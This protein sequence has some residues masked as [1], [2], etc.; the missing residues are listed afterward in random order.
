MQATSYGARSVVRATPK[1]SLRSEM[2]L[3]MPILYAC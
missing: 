1:I 3:F 2:F